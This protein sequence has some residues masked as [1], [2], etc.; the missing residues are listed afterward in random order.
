MSQP[1]QCAQ[2]IDSQEEELVS[3]QALPLEQASPNSLTMEEKA[4]NG[5]GSMED[6]PSVDQLWLSSSTNSSTRRPRKC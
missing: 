4:S 6:F 2:E 5:Y 3:I 1:D